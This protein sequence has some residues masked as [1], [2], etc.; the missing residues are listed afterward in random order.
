MK[1]YDLYLFDF[2]GTLFDTLDSLIE[3]YKLGF[4]KYGI[5]IKEDEYETFLGESLIS[6]FSRKGV[7]Q[8]DV[9]EAI[10]YFNEMANTIE[11]CSKTKLYPETLKLFELLNNKKINY[12]IVTGSSSVRVNMVLDYFKI[13][14]SNIKVIVGSNMYKKPKPDKEPLEMALKMIN[15]TNKKDKVLY[16]G[17][18]LQDK[19]CADAANVECVLLNRRNNINLLSVF[20]D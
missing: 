18:T 1:K 13:D 19:L 2:D 9:P 3:I 8:E 15:Y 10:K 12:G 6:A 20:N 17:D 4:L 5:E 16:I 11:V 7:K 14:K